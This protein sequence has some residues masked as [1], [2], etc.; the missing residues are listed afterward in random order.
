MRTGDEPLE[1]IASRNSQNVSGNTRQLDPGAFKGLV[2]PLSLARALLN[3]RLAIA[4][5][6]T[7]FANLFGWHETGT[8]QPV[9]DELR[10][11]GGVS[12]VGLAARDVAQMLRVEQP[13]LELR[14]EQRVDWLPVDAGR[15]HSHERNRVARKTVIEFEQIADRRAEALREGQQFTVLVNDTNARHD[16]R[17]VN[18]EPS[19]ATNE[20]FHKAPPQASVGNVVQR[21]LIMKSLKFVLAAT[22]KCAR[23]SR[24]PLRPDSWHQIVDR[25]RWTTPQIFSSA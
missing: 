25:R 23:G 20:R 22:V 8:N 21:S 9:S 1:H 16:R 19:A 11:P 4:S 5:Y 3:D 7:Q 13:A 24:V 14:L 12:D 6:F 17:F 2:Q 18:V 15:L 10:N